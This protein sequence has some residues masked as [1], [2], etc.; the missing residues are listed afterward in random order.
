MTLK[1]G[2]RVGEY[3]MTKILPD[4]ITLEADQD[5]FEVLLFDP[6]SPK[7]RTEI[8]MTVAPP[9]SK[10]PLAGSPPRPSS[11]PP[12]L[13]PPAS[14]TPLPPG[15]LPRPGDP[16]QR[17]EPQTPRPAPSSPVPEPR[18]WRGRLPLPAIGESRRP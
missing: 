7:K 5:R 11:P 12:L 15:Q 16:A 8:R 4:R 9:P 17:V 6:R 10:G 1:I 13:P 3:K 2:D 18:A 14:A